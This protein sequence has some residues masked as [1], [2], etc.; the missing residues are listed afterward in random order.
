M[1]AVY[2]SKGQRWSRTPNVEGLES[3]N[4]LSATAASPLSAE[5]HALKF[6]LPPIK[7]PPINGTIRGTITSITPTSKTTEVVTYTAI[8]K[9]NI[10][11]DGRGG[12]QHTLTS[13][14]VKNH[15]SNDT[16]ANGQATVT[17]TTDTVAITYSGTGHTN[18]N[19]GF[20]ANL[21]GK[22]TSIAGLDVGLSG[23]FSATLSGNNRTGSFTISFSVKL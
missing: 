5:V 4:L 11:G 22:A 6:T 10:I 12:G 3:R 21:K 1:R 9:A 17:G 7:I 15:P 2:Q 8:G 18:A 23:P 16:Y 13:K 20:T 19:G 14:P